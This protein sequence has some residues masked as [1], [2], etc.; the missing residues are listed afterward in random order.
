M[1]SRIPSEVL[2][3]VKDILRLPDFSHLL[4]F[5]STGGGCISNGGKLSASNGTYFLKWN[6]VNQFP[7][8]FEAE[9]RGLQ[10][11][12]RQDVIRIPEVIGVSDNGRFQCLIL[13]FIEQATRAKG[14]WD[15]LG[16]Q[17]AA[18]HQC[19]NNSFGLDHANYVGSLHQFNEQTSS[20]VQFFIEQR[21]DRQLQLAM[22]NGRAPQHWE[23]QFQSLFNRLSTM[24]PEEK[25]ALLHGDLW[26]GNLLTDETGSPCL[27]DPAVYFGHREADLA[28]TKLFGG[29][30]G[31][32][33]AAYHE[34]FPLESGVEE[35]TEI[36]NL[37][38]LLVHVNLFGG[39]YIHSVDAILRRF[40]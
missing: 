4:S 6:D 2:E 3:L 26:N 18:L 16:R 1:I 19:S 12:S 28:M 32:F 31:R 22:E 11:L 23:A 33:Y 9:S 13:K 25:P 7:G 27:I 37:Y 30:E 40:S 10:L 20:W 5:S 21:L 14:Y 34:A 36:F 29:F 8:M 24:L 38:P 39:S 15:L 17:L 35:R